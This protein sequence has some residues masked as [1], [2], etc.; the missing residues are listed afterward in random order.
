MRIKINL[1]QF[2]SELLKKKQQKGSIQI[3]AT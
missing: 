3:Y 1:E 2:D